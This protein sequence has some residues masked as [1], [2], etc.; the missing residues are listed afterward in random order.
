[1]SD[2]PLQRQFRRYQ[3]HLPFLHRP[4]SSRANRVRAGWTRDLSERGVCVELD[5]SLPVPTR[6]QVCLQTDRGVIDAEA[7]V[8]WAG[9]PPGP[10]RSILHGLAF[11]RLA[12]DQLQ[13]LQ[14]LLLSWGLGRRVG[15]RIPFE[16]AVTCQHKGEPG[17]L[18]SGRGRNGSRN[19]LLLRLPQ[20]VPPGTTLELT[21]HTDRGPLTVEGTIVWVAPPEGRSPGGPIRHGLRLTA[22]G[23]PTVLALGL[24]L[25]VPLKKTSWLAPREGSA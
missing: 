15:V 3:I 25:A 4:S 17:P 21:L 24:A 18:I 13:S 20:V 11:T 2:G 5:Q 9:A 19:G 8:V 7:E 14:Y 10:Q 6:L 22:L 23:W 12:P 16:V 1:M